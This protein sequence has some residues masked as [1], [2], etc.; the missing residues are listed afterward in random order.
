[1]DTDKENENDATGKIGQSTHIVE[2]DGYGEHMHPTISYNPMDYHTS[3]VHGKIQRSIWIDLDFSTNDKKP[4]LL[5]YSFI[6]FYTGSENSINNSLL[7]YQHILAASCGALYHKFKFTITNQATTRKRLLTSSGT[8]TETIDFET[9][10]NLLL[11]WGTTKE[12]TPALTATE[13]TTPPWHLSQGGDLQSGNFEYKLE[14]L[15]TGHMKTIVVEPTKIPEGMYWEPFDIDGS[16]TDKPYLLPCI[17]QTAKTIALNDQ[18]IV[19]YTNSNYNSL[20]NNIAYN[21]LPALYLDYPHIKDETGTMKFIYRL[22]IDFEIDYTLFT[23]PTCKS[24]K[25]YMRNIYK[26]PQAVYNPTTK[27]FTAYFTPHSR[28]D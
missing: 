10:Q 24:D 23:N 18:P 13:I 2:Q 17:Q 19:L 16:I 3:Q 21:N 1:M 22:K 26:L 6:Q 4:F 7:N 27:K 20:R 9:S 28:Y 5:P 12:E 25:S 14:E 15:A 11:M 8:T